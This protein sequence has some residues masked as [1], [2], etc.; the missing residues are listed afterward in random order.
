[1]SIQKLAQVVCAVALLCGSV[2]GQAVSSNIIGTVTDP[3]DASVPGAEV[4]LREQATGMVRKSTT[5]SEGIFRFT[6][7]PSGTYAITLKAQGFKT[8]TQEGI[9]RICLPPPE[10]ACQEPSA[11]DSEKRG[12]EASRSACWT[13]GQRG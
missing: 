13:L 7:L 11:A 3:G 10:G 6:N 2:F 12:G 8:Y 5:G 4:Q 1:M 9:S